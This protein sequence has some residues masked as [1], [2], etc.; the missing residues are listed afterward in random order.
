MGPRELLEQQRQLG[1][2]PSL[3]CT[4]WPL[5]VAADAA[6]GDQVPLLVAPSFS[7]PQPYPLVL[8]QPAPPA[9]GGGVLVHLCLDPEEADLFVQKV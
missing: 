4:Q 8:Q 6:L 5:D 3:S 7:Q 2:L 9:M 1:L